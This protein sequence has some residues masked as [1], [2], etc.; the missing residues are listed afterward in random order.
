MTERKSTE[1]KTAEQQRPR[2]PEYT[3][4]T[5]VR[6]AKEMK[7]EDGGGRFRH[8]GRKLAKQG[9]GK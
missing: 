3:T 4:D 5:R 7:P 1:H 6:T 2:T 8:I 9:S